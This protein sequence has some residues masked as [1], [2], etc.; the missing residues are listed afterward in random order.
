MNTEEPFE[1]AADETFRPLQLN[2][3]VDT[4]SISNHPTVNMLQQEAAIFEA[5]KQVEKAEGLPDF[6]VGYTNQSL[7]GFQTVNGREKYFGAGDRFGFVNIGV[8]IPLTFGATNARI[9]SLEFKKRA[10]EANALQQ[11][12][13]LENQL[14]N[15][16]QQYHQDLKKY[17]YY[18]DQALSNA[19]E[20]VAAAQ[21]GYRT[22]DI[23]YVEYLYALEMASGIQLNYLK[24]I[25]NV[26]Q[27]VINIYSLINK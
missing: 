9:K 8:A 17:N 1:I 18:K 13:S 6:T 4:G 27:S 12:N 26:N 19:N 2:D 25:E 15:A 5:S 3:L 7:I 23:S 16:M 24:S 14:E 10:A 22:G 11:K 20:I 21:L